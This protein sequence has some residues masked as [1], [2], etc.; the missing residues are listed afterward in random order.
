MY[1][2]RPNE[3]EILRL[4]LAIQQVDNITCLL[5]FNKFKTYLYNHLS[6][7]KYELDRQ[8]TNLRISDNIDK[9]TQK[10]K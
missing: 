9:E 8:L 5:E 3:K 2:E 4:T 6:S 1:R 10:G 7:I